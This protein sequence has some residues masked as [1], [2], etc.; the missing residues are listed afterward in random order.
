MWSRVFDWLPTL[1][2]PAHAGSSLSDFSTLKMEDIHSSE[3]SIHSRSGRHH[4]VTTAK[5]SNLTEECLIENNHY[6]E[7]VLKYETIH[8][9][10][11]FCYSAYGRMRVHMLHRKLASRV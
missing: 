9:S 10:T 5:T 6:E 3:T 2:L 11:A 4:I 8:L 7:S 1:Q